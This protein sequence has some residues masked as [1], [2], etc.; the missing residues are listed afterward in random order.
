MIQEENVQIGEDTFT[1]QSLPTSDAL[2]LLG[3][4]TRI[5]GGLGKGMRDFPGS[6]EELNM[7][8]KEG[9]LNPGEMVEGFLAKLD[10]EQTT[11]VL[12]AVV[13]KSLVKPQFVKNSKTAFSDWYEDRFSGEGLSDLMLLVKKI[14]EINYGNALV[15]LGKQIGEALTKVAATAPIPPPNG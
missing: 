2:I 14:F 5:V 9:V 15:W 1:I 6:I 11:K 8:L 4:L 7:A 13:E 3:K 10:P 12:K